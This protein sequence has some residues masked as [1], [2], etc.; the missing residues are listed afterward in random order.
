MG[1][2][3]PSPAGVL[4]EFWRKETETG[5][6]TDSWWNQLANFFLSIKFQFSMPSSTVILVFFT[7]S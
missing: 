5:L 4:S 6:R 1:L 3:P 2:L 7:S